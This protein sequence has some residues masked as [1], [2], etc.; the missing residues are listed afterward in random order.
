MIQGPDI[1]PAHRFM[2]LEEIRNRLAQY[3]NDVNERLKFLEDQ[4]HT[5][6]AELKQ[7]S[8]E[9]A[10][11]I[12]AIEA[13]DFGNENRMFRQETHIYTGDKTEGRY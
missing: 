9:H 11:S 4:R 1:G 2:T 13:F 8:L 6:D 7:A 12:K 10:A 3:H 5:L